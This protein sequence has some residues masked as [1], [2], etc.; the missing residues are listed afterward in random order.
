VGVEPLRGSYEVVVFDCIFGEGEAAV[1]GIVDDGRDA[2]D[3]RGFIAHLECSDLPC[4][5][6]FALLEHVDGWDVADF[7]LGPGLGLHSRGARSVVILRLWLRSSRGWSV[8]IV[9][10]GWRRHRGCEAA[11]EGVTDDGDLSTEEGLP[12]SAEFY[13]LCI[14]FPKESQGLRVVGRGGHLE[15]FD[16]L[17][18]IGKVFSHWTLPHALLTKAGRLSKGRRTGFARLR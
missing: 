7:C 18:Q 10:G 15:Q 14:G 11:V 17:T 13:Q 16:E 9:G 6:R 3:V 5:L 2:A 8:A 1:A 12:V 4:V